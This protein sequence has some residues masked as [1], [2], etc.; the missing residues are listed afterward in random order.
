MRRRDLL[1]LHR[2]LIGAE[3]FRRR[4]C[5]AE[6][7]AQLTERP[8]GDA[9]HRREHRSACAAWYGP[10]RRYSIGRGTCRRRNAGRR[11]IAQADVE[12]EAGAVGAR[13]AHRDFAVDT[14][15]VRRGSARRRTAGPVFAPASDR[16]PAMRLP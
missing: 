5:R 1:L 3:H 7:T 12:F 16:V 2:L 13:I 8:V 6:L 9:R 15:I 4:Q 11:R 14:F 10:M